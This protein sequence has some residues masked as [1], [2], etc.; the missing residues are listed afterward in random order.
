MPKSAPDLPEVPGLPS[1][2]LLRYV[3]TGGLRPS[4][5]ELVLYRDGRA[6]STRGVRRRTGER[7]VG[8]EEVWHVVGHLATAGFFELPDE[9]G[10]QRP[11]GYAHE[12]T[13]R[14][15]DGSRTVVLYDGSVPPTV[16][17]ELANLRR[18][19]RGE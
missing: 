17:P 2:A 19:L 5:D 6:E 8:T 7:D 18:L 14:S 3:R 15:G 16:A 10:E 12:I 4:S 9:V 11:D 13:V 1:G